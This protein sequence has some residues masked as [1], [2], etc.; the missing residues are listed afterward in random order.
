[1]GNRIDEAEITTAV[2]A[3]LWDAGGSATIAQIR[4]A[5]PHFA[6]LNP[7]DRALS[8]TRPGEQMWERQVRNIVCHRDAYGNA[9]NEGR[10][11]WSTGRL[12]LRDGP[13]ISLLD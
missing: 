1:M 13:Q 11:V 7:M 6:D 4:R 3:Y 2:E 12:T 8:R 9:V 5:L 10:I